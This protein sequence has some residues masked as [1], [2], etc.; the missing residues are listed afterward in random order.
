M[1]T[2]CIAAPD[3]WEQPGTCNSRDG[4]VIDPRSWTANQKKRMA[5]LMEKHLLS[6][7]RITEELYYPRLSHLQKRTSPVI[8]EACTTAAG[9]LKLSKIDALGY[10]HSNGWIRELDH[11]ASRDISTEVQ[12]VARVSL[13]PLLTLYSPLRMRI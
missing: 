12:E 11:Q 1:G 7:W 13:L 10:H 4:S 3:V 9:F 5:Q 6:N 2:G 8:A